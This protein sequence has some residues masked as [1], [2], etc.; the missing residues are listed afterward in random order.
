MKKE[1][2]YDAAVLIIA[3][4]KDG[5][6]VVVRDP[7]FKVPYLKLP[8]G[9]K[10]EEESPA[11]CASRELKEETGIK[12]PW[13][14]L[15]RVSSRKKRGHS[16]YVYFGIIHSWKTL[17]KRG[18]D[19]EVVEIFSLDE[20]LNRKDFL[21]EHGDILIKAISCIKRAGVNIT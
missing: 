18:N 2:P 4:S 13:T 10:E 9:H 5:R 20:V 15:F 12:I 11:E 3:V 14:K 21:H 6:I 8:G 7:S 17:L 1:V 19:G 16:K